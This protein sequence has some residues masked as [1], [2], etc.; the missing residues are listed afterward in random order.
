MVDLGDVTLA[1]LAGGAG[2]RMGGPKAWLKYQNEPILARLHRRL[3]WPG[4][5]LLISSPGREHPPGCERF[6][7]EACDAVAE[8]GPLRG[9]YT[10]AIAATT[11]LIVA[12]PVD[13]PQLRQEPLAR[14]VEAL[15]SSIDT[16]AACYQVGESSKPLPVVFQKNLQDGLKRRIDQSDLSVNRWLRAIGARYIEA[17]DIDDCFWKNLNE[18]GDW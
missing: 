16:Q 11:D 4:P 5:T 18:P 10:A 3:G 12:V 1:V 13:M 17:H 15:Q 7:A 2:R 9:I 8:Q 14:L 6:T